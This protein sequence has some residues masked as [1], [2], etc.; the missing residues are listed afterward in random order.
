MH[1]YIYAFRIY[2]NIAKA[3]K[4]HHYQIVSLKSIHQ[5]YQDIGIISFNNGYTFRHKRFTNKLKK[6]K[7]MTKRVD[8]REHKNQK[9]SNDF[10]KYNYVNYSIEFQIHRFILEQLEIWSMTIFVNAEVLTNWK[11]THYIR[12]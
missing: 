1:I 10:A 11:R 6:I 9:V 7:W 12:T 4:K 5:R 2:N 3:D 8:V